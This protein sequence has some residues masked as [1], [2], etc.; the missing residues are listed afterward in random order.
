MDKINLKDM[1][2]KFKDDIVS[3]PGGEFFRRCFTCGT[4]T[5]ACPVAEVHDEY[6]PRKIIRMAILGMRKEVLSSD[7]LWMCS[8]CYTCYALCPQNVKFTDVISILRDMAIKEGYVSKER[9][10]QAKETDK[11]IQ[12]LRCKIIDNKLHPEEKKVKE[13]KKSIEKEL[14]ENW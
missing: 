4:C 7:I 5:A 14:S 11:Q 1:D 2:P 12:E 9:L 3:Q 13:I 6:D 8:R 10:E